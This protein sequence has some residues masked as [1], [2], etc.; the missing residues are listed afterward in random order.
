MREIK[1]R[2]WAASLI[3]MKSRPDVPPQNFGSIPQDFAM[4]YIEQRAKE[5]QDK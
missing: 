4:A 3:H 5:E 1:F 2:E